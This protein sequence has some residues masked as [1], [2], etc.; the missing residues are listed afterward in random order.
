MYVELIY[1]QNTCYIWSR[2]DKV[3]QDETYKWSYTLKNINRTVSYEY[4]L[5][6]LGQVTSDNKSTPSN[7]LKFEYKVN[8]TKSVRQVDL[9]SKIL[10]KVQN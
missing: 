7:V 4:L 6:I 9:T 5:N 8:N 3:I 1:L 2:E 10:I